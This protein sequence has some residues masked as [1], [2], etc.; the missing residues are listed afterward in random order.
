ME[1]FPDADRDKRLGVN[2]SKLREDDSEDDDVDGDSSGSSQVWRQWRGKGWR[3]RHL[4][5]ILVLAAT[6]AGSG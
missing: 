1:P 5:R 2:L 6:R 3:R 4:H